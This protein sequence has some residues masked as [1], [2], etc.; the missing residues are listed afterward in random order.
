MK[1]NQTTYLSEIN[2]KDISKYFGKW[3]EE[4]SVLNEK[5]KNAEPFEHIIIPNF[6]SKKYAD[7][8]YKKYP[9]DYEKWHKYS[10]PL[11]VKYACDDILNLDE[12]IQKLFYLLS[13][14]EIIDKIKE[15][16]NIQNLTYDEYLHGAGL[17]AHPR[18]GRLN[19]HLDYEK[20][21]YTGT[22][23]RLNIIL[24]M[25][26]DWNKDWNGATELWNKDMTKCITKSNVQF[27]TAIIFK[28]NE[29]SWHGVP[30]II[31]CPENIYRKTLAYYYVSPLENTPNEMKIGNDGSGYRTKATFVKRPQDKED[32][33]MNQLYKIRPYRRIKKEDMD[34]IW[35]E[36]NPQM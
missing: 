17:H 14:N 21:P 28:T 34:K 2:N 20:H 35:P 23:R 7:I 22:Q 36:W 24:Y 25:N 31:M 32:E 9:D 12:E 6:L 13:S 26:K 15:I 3:I 5:F 30:E 11:E 10:N 33:R 1:K 29:I 4:T 27:N 18:F 19:M 8:I 16:T